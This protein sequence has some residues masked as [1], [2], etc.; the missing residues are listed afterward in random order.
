MDRDRAMAVPSNVAL[1][2]VCAQLG[3]HGRAEALRGAYRRSARISGGS[4]SKDD[5][6]LPGSLSRLIS[7]EGKPV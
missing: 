5:Q 1:E 3:R 4:S 7:S 2:A 6:L